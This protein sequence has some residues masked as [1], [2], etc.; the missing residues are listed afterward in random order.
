MLR[1]ASAEAAF[2]DALALA[3]LA[4]YDNG[5]NAED[6]DDSPVAETPRKP[7]RARRWLGNALLLILVVVIAGVGIVV[8]SFLRFSAEVVGLEPP[9]DIAKAD[10]IVVLT[11]GSLR[12]D[13]AVELLDDG[14]A[15]RLLISGV[16][17]A[18]TGQ[19][20]QRQTS[21]EP[22]LFEC[23]V[24]IGHDAIDTRGNAK[25]AALWVRENGYRDV[26]VVTAN[27]HMPRSLLEL[28]RVDNETRFIPYPVFPPGHDKVDWWRDPMVLNVLAAEYGKF[29]IARFRHRLGTPSP[30]GL[31]SSIAAQDGPQKANM[32]G[33]N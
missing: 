18:T 13:R 2:V 9:R 27:Y 10:G 6:T 8:G 22:A 12:I 33:S 24:D 1:F 30:D 15:G 5:M 20:I 4:L 31:R 32:A 3:T 19:Q 17:P 11:G 14:V 16:N 21:A 26:I 29:I 23:C 28:Q 7:G 25:E